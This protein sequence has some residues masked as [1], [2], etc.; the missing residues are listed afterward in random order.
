MW[1]GTMMKYKPVLFLIMVCALCNVSCGKNKDGTNTT[2]NQSAAVAESPLFEQ[3]ILAG[4]SESLDDYRNIEGFVIGEGEVDPRE[5]GKDAPDHYMAAENDEIII[6]FWPNV[7]DGDGTSYLLKFVDIKKK[8]DTYFLGQFIGM[9][10]EEIFNCF[11]RP[12]DYE[13]NGEGENHI[14]YFSTDGKKLVNF[15]LENNVVIR[16]AFGYM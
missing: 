6:G 10:P 11:T 9:T 13:E 7:G 5:M 2:D 1:M 4:V 3:N 16:A 8:T 14:V 15:W 12:A